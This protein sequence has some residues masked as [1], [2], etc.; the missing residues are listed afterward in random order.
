MNGKYMTLRTNSKGILYTDESEYL[1]AN[2][3]SWQ[4]ET[5]RI[6]ENTRKKRGRPKKNV[7]KGIIFTHGEYILDFS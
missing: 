4:D 1:K 3:K 6:T 5:K 7:P 2:E